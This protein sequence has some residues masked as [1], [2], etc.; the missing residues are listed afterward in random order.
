MGTSG[1]TI[2]TIVSVAVGALLAAV[3]LIGLISQTVN[4]ASDNPGDVNASIPYG[5]TQ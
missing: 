1:K 4:S 3:T 2:G 5:T